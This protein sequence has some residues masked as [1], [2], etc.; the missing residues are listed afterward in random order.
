MQQKYVSYETT[1]SF[2]CTL[3]N[4]WLGQIISYQLEACVIVISFSN[5]D[6]D[7][8][9][10]SLKVRNDV[11]NHCVWSVISHSEHSSI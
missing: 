9:N 10:E 11:H 3:Q 8:E 7:V 1:V 4:K 6:T 5:E 2:Y